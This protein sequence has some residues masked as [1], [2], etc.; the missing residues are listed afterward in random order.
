MDAEEVESLWRERDRALEAIFGPMEQNVLAGVSDSW[1]WGGPPT[2]NV[3]RDQT[4]R[5]SYCT[6]EMSNPGLG[7]QSKSY[8][9]ALVVRSDSPLAVGESSL[10]SAL[11]ADIAKSTRDMSIGIGHTI[12]PLHDC[13][14]PLV[15]VL[16][17]PMPDHSTL[18]FGA[19]HCDLVLCV[20]IMQSE[21]D[22]AK[23]HSRSDLAERL[24]AASVLPFTDP[25]R[26]SVR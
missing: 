15:R 6:S 7:D 10:A 4:D 5:I 25:L 14:A 22:F 2:I 9:M 26:A 12:G 13:Y 18:W 21:L 20:G 1:L 11:L 8:E 19:H 3:Y 16:F 17:L 24:L 23:Q